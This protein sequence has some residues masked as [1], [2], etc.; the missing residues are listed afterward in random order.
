MV[1]EIT[2]KNANKDANKNTPAFHSRKKAK[3][4]SA[5]DEDDLICV[6]GVPASADDDLPLSSENTAFFQG[7]RYVLKNS[8][9]YNCAAGTHLVNDSQ[10]L[11]EMRTA[12]P[13]DYVLAGMER[14]KMKSRGKR[15]ME[16]IVYEETRKR[17]LILE[18]VAYISEFHTNI[19]SGYSMWKELKIW[20]C[21]HTS[22]LVKGDPM[23]G[24]KII[25]LISVK[26]M[27][28]QLVV[29]YKPVQHYSSSSSS[30]FFRIP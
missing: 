18:N 19:I 17:N 8:T 1:Q 16:G 10:L 4:D 29:E 23:K 25:L 28:R 26:P 6:V 13:D 14:L 9:I 12:D 15:R 30:S 7:S 5:D 20:H 3:K 2:G 27:Y 22:Q 21:S 11:T 24:E